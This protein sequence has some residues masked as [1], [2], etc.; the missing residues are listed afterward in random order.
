MS[1]ELQPWGGLGRFR[2]SA[3][4]D[5][6][7]WTQAKVHPAHFGNEA[8]AMYFFDQDNPELL[9]KIL[10]GCAING[11]YWLY[12][13]AATDLDSTVRVVRQWPSLG[14]DLDVEYEIPGGTFGLVRIEEEHMV[15]RD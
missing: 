12:V 15:C 5:N 9:V 4:F 14:V 10:D 1:A 2:V 11:S 7:G 8:V 6:D 3:R 13:S